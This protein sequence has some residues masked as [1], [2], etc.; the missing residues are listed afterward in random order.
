MSNDRYLSPFGNPSK[1]SRIPL[2][3]T[4][5][6]KE[7]EKFRKAWLKEIEPKGPIERMYFK[8]LLHLAWE[9]E[10]LRKAEVALLNT[11]YRETLEFFIAE[12][13]TRADREA[14]ECSEKARVLSFGFFSDPDARTRIAKLLAGRGLDEAAI[15]VKVRQRCSAEFAELHRQVISAEVRRDKAMR[16]FAE[17][18]ASLSRHIKRN[19]RA[20]A[21]QP[22]EDDVPD[23]LARAAQALIDGG[24][25][26]ERHAA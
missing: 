11:A 18:R 3:I 21:R 16:A 26:T 15:E 20:S 17:Y 1:S 19:G 25:K 5:P 4:E 6:R 2:L 24:G 8:N 14:W 22:D 7:F 9:V 13:M 12:L 10:R 23:S